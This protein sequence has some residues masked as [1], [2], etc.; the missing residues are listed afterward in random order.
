MLSTCSS[1]SQS[2][3]PAPRLLL[4]STATTKSCNVSH[5]KT[6]KNISSIHLQLFADKHYIKELITTYLSV[7]IVPL[8]LV[9]EINVMSYS[10]AEQVSQH[11]RNCSL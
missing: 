2:V 9:Y 8:F 3:T 10:K 4:T 1:E 11:L 7:S 6:C 5:Y